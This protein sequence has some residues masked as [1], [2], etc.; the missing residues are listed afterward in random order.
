MAS[1]LDT[2]WASYDWTIDL[3]EKLRARHKESKKL[4]T[5]EHT[6]VLFDKQ[7][8]EWKQ[9]TTCKAWANVV[10]EHED[11]GDGAGIRIKKRR[12]VHKNTKKKPSKK[13][14][15]VHK[16]T[17]KNPSKKYRSRKHKHTKRR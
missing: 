6:W 5:V 9:A 11:Y 14:R 10:K 3:Q 2:Y 1:A 17:K 16:K 15:S 13:Y 8:P 12:S 4:S 7:D